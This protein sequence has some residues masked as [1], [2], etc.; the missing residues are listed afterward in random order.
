MELNREQIVKA[1]ECVFSETCG[2]CVYKDI[3][4]C[5]EQSARD[6]ISFINLQ[7]QKIKELTEELE[8]ERTWANSMIDNL[9]DDIKEL[10]EENK[11]LQDLLQEAQE[12]NVAWVEDNGKLRQEMKSKRCNM[13]NFEKIKSMSIEELT[14]WLDE[15][16]Q[17]D[18]APW[19][20]WF[21]RKYCKNCD[22]IMCHYEDST[23]EF[24]CAW[25]E[26]NDGCKFLP[27]AKETP[28][29]KEI[30]KMWLKADCKETTKTVDDELDE[31]F[32]LNDARVE[33]MIEWEKK[34][35]S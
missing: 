7:D 28:S 11:C 20:F 8:K 26:L 34:Y 17:F 14:E 22:P 21:D 9:R 12:Y 18:T 19:M 4:K 30:I 32:A 3:D 10:A 13:N 5:Q 2:S 1:L 27:D 6:A 23:H 33:E 24:P 31:L 16:G 35:G 15:Y 29:N 25:C